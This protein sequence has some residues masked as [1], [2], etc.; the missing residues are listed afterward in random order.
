MH[1]ASFTCVHVYKRARA[2]ARARMFVTLEGGLPRL[3]L[4][5]IPR[6]YDVLGDDASV[7]AHACSLTALK[8]SA[9]GRAVG[10]QYGWHNFDLADAGACGG[11]D[12]V[13]AVRVS[14]ALAKDPQ[15]MLALDKGA[16]CLLRLNAKCARQLQVDVSAEVI[17]VSIVDVAQ[18]RDAKCA[19][20]T[21]DP[22]DRA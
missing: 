11:E 3:R 16:T 1:T 8:K 20:L 7:L 17:E 6:L 19:W 15:A 14:A 9:W 5:N 13:Y 22:L 18:R 10:A 2:R 12:A 4:G 21:V